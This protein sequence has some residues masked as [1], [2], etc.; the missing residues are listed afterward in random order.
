MPRRLVMVGINAGGS[1]VQ[2]SAPS[3]TA[4]SPEDKSNQLASDPNPVHSTF[5]DAVELAALH[6]ERTPVDMEDDE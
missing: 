1:T 3:P 5:I 6:T 2:M 4:A